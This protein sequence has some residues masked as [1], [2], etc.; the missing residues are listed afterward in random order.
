MSSNVTLPNKVRSR[1]CFGQLLGPA[2]IMQEKADEIV[3][4]VKAV[5][6]ERIWQ[7][8]LERGDYPLYSPYVYELAERLGMEPDELQAAAAAQRAERRKG[9][10]KAKARAKDSDEADDEA[11]AAADDG[12]E[13]GPAPP[14]PYINYRG[15]AIIPVNGHLSKMPTSL[16]HMF[17]GSSTVG[18]R[19]ALA[20]A[21]ADSTVQRI[22]FHV[23][24]PGG[25]VPGVGDLADEIFAASQVKPTATYAEDLMGS[26]A[27]W[28]GSQSE[29]AFAGPYTQVGSIGVYTVIHDSSEAASKQGVKVHVVKTGA[30]K[31]SI[32]PGAPVTKEALDK[33]QASV[34]RWHDVFIDTVARGRDLPRAKVAALATGEVWLASD[35]LKHGLIDRIA[36]FH[37]ALAEFE[38]M[39]ATQ[40][41]AVAAKPAA[42]T[43]AKPPATRKRM[44]RNRAASADAAAL[45]EQADTQSSAAAPPAVDSL[46]D[47]AAG[48]VVSAVGEQQSA[49]GAVS[50][51]QEAMFAPEES[52]MTP[53]P[54]TAGQPAGG[55]ANALTPE[56]I[57][58]LQADA[59]AGREAKEAV[60][61]LEQRLAAQDQATLDE[62]RERI[63]ADYPLADKAEVAA[64]KDHAS[65]KAYEGVLRR[66][67]GDQRGVTGDPAAGASA[68]GTQAT[69]KEFDAWA[70]HDDWKA[71]Q[72]SATLSIP[73]NA[74]KR[75]A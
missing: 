21:V 53:P 55:S 73:A 35:A 16:G 40:E 66:A 60:A 47:A 46:A 30:H 34:Q 61:R 18:M 50:Y 15:T 68:D 12:D 43:A 51:S 42:A 62:M 23:D 6:I 54:D 37:E 39:T 32:I 71:Q 31:G 75:G 14:P 72:P 8:G 25:T 63:L 57:Q 41:P 64:C 58:R 9:G 22:M 4:A 19:K 38:A 2:A 26:A 17:G 56:A 65:L 59:A 52:S 11:E 45:V 13:S 44:Q 49:N 24:S 29:V 5:G 67:G 28:L 27:Y 33:V 3:D 74:G 36:S 48:I 69:T 70:A 7:M 20:L 1:P 10:K